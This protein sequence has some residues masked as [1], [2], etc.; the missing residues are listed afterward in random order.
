MKKIFVFSLLV[1]A[2]VSCNND[3]NSG[4]GTGQRSTDADTT[5]TQVQSVQNA[6]GNMPDTSNSIN[7]GTETPNDTSHVKAPARR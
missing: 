4:T 3:T 5:A 1:I 7:I 2:C 6:N